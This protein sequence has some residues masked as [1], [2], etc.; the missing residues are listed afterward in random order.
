MGFYSARS[1]HAGGVNV[2]MADGSV[3]FVSN[4]VSLEAW[5]GMATIAGQEIVSLP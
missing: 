1:H 3:H 5:R 4:G 2:G